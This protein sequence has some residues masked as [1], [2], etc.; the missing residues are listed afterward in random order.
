MTVRELIEKLKTLDP[1][2]RVRMG[3]GVN[4]REITRINRWVSYTEYYGLDGPHVDFVS[5][6]EAELMQILCDNLRK[7]TV[8]GKADMMELW[9]P[10]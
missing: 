10:A 7:L 9:K 2:R 3:N 5:E 8:D 6:R 1:D 4:A